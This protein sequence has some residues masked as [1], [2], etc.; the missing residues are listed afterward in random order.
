MIKTKRFNFI[1]LLPIFALLIGFYLAY[2]RLKQHGEII[3]ISFDDAKGLEVGKTKIRY[4]NIEIGTVTA[5]NFAPN[6]EEIIVTAQMTKSASSLLRQDSEFWVVKPQ[7]SADGFSGFSTILS[8][9]F[10]AVS[11]GQ[12]LEFSKQFKALKDIPI[13]EKN[14]AGIRVN[15]ITQTLSGLN[16]GSAVY[17]HG[18]KV[19]KIERIKFAPNFKHLI[20][21]AFI[22]EPYDSLISPNTHFWNTSGIQASLGSDGVKV[23]MNSAESLIFG[24]ISFITSTSLIKSSN[25]SVSNILFPLHDNENPSSGN[26]N[27]NKDYYVLYFP[28]SVRGLKVGAS[29]N[30][31]GIDIGRVTEVRLIYD[32]KEKVAKI[33]VLIEIEPDRITR[34]EGKNTAESNIIVELIERGLSAS[35]ENN[36]LITGDK[37]VKLSINDKSSPRKMEKDKYTDHW[38]MPSDATPIGKL[39]DDVNEI[40]QN[41]KKLPIEEIGN[42]LVA[43]T[44]NLNQLSQQLNQQL[45]SKSELSKNLNQ[46]LK[47]Y[48]KLATELDKDTELLVKNLNQVLKKLDN[49]LNL[50]SGNS[51]F[52]FMLEKTLKTVENTMRDVGIMVRKINS[53]PNSLIF[54]E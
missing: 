7:V 39:A 6:L 26:S 20:I 22:R 32:E 19:G 45:G 31:N 5:I 15:L 14:E 16:E 1:W 21:T 17:Y 10:I 42:N 18:M 23:K 4:K 44:H 43:L 48:S 29:V 33:P 37:Y 24:G 2:D 35:L 34:V 47:N 52:Y 40:V 41:V 46:T 36:N 11:P 8:G 12:S 30:F 3:T 28:D 13:V 49:T 27:L 25:V 50:L 51:S 53:K 38:I 54:G 9:S